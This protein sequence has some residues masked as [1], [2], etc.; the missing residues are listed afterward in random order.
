M[1]AGWKALADFQGT[2]VPA[3]SAKRFKDHAEVFIANPGLIP[4]QFVRNLCEEAGF[5][6]LLETDDISGYGAGIFYILST[7]DGDKHFRLPK[8]VSPDKVLYGPACRPKGNGY[9]VSLPRGKVFV[10]SVKGS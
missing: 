3:V 9:F 2:D 5:S 4:Q 1:P 7:K 10:L 6:P 8:G